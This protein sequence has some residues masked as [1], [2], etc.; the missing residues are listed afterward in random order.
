MSASHV[1]ETGF[2]V[3]SLSKQEAESTISGKKLRHEEVRVVFA[4]VTQLEMAEFGLKFR[5]V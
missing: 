5:K 4:Q 2:G 1:Q 3:L